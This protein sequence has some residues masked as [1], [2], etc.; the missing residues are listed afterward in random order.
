[1]MNLQ[2]TTFF[3]AL[4][5]LIFLIYSNIYTFTFSHLADTFIHSDLRMTYKWGQ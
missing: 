1:M 2:Q 4:I 3:T 5:M